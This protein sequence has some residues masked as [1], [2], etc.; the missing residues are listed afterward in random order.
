MGVRT[1]V[2]HSSTREAMEALAADRH[3]N[4][5]VET[6]SPYLCLDTD[7][8]IGAY[9]KMLPPI[10][11]PESRKALWDGIRSG[12]IDTIG[13]DNTVLTAGE[14]QVSSGMREAGAGY[15]TLVPTWSA[16]WTRAFIARSCPLRSW[17]P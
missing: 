3:P 5:Y 7:S 16:S 6:T 4:L 10:R 9:G 14:K 15:P 12:L 17:C 13:T 11:E 1:Y 2:V 8:P